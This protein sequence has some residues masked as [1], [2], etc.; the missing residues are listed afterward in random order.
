MNSF[1]FPPARTSGAKFPH[2]SGR[3]SFFFWLNLNSL[4]SFL[5]VDPSGT[6]NFLHELPPFP[7]D[8]QVLVPA[9][10]FHHSFSTT[11]VDEVHFID[12][13][14]FSEPLDDESPALS[15]VR[16]RFGPSP[17]SLNGCRF[18]V[19]VGFLW[20]EFFPYHLKV[21]LDPTPFSFGSHLN[22]PAFF[23]FLVWANEAVGRLM[24][25]HYALNSAI[26][27]FFP[28]WPATP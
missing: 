27:F 10:C 20:G 16:L 21:F 7:N 13:V 26:R 14:F 1:F 4:I 6:D 22:S 12:R 24:T 18:L 17:S 11:R 15:L 2:Q 25:A 23:L 19:L 5:A 3:F 8:Q 9:R 28:S